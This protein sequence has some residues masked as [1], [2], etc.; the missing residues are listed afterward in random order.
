MIINRNGYGSN[1]N[2]LTL[3]G[4]TITKC[5]FNNYGN[6]KM[7]NEI[8][9]YK[10]IL[11][12]KNK[13]C[14]V[15]PH[16]YKLNNDSIEMAFLKGYTPLYLSYHLFTFEE[17]NI[18]LKRII[19]QLYHI[20]NINIPVNELQFKNDLYIETIEKIK[21][22]TEDT[23]LIKEESYNHIKYVNGIE[24]QSFDDV[25]NIVKKN[26]EK[27]FNSSNIVYNYGIIHGDCQFNNILIN[28]NK[29]LKFI[30]PRGYY[31]NT[32]LYGLVEY[33]I[34]KIC[35]ALSGYDYFDNS[36][37]TDLNITDNNITVHIEIY[38]YDFIMKQSM[39]TKTLLCC[40]WLGNAH[41]FLNDKNKCITSYFI[42]MYMC[43]QF[44]L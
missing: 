4:E 44:L 26:V 35:F 39:I 8:N 7:E 43:S 3:S 33:D 11:K 1:F 34:A 6:K 18:C 42:A 16:I 21:T 28:E 25:L 19:E 9:F 38:D 17:K 20:H 13:F 15:I 23:L 32:Q 30:D 36:V 5:S 14:S 12:T 27:Y 37:I 10:Y 24:I 22:R 31:G 40:I 29:D 41:I 2:I